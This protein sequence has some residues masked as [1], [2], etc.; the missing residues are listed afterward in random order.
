[1]GSEMCIR[2]RRGQKLKNIGQAARIDIEKFIQC[3]VMLN[4]W[5]KVRNGWS[6]N[7]DILKSLS[8]EI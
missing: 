1:M 8:F 4:V 3:K 5:I 6:N 2:D 7:E